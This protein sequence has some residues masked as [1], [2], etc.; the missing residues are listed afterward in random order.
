MEH[1]R[2]Y[3]GILGWSILSNDACS[4]VLR[5]ALDYESSSYSGLWISMFFCV[6]W[7]RCI[8]Q[9][10]QLLLIN[11]LYH[12]WKIY[13]RRCEYEGIFQRDFFNNND[14]AEKTKYAWSYGV[15]LLSCRLFRNW[16]RN[17]ST[18]CFIPGIIMAHKPWR[19]LKGQL[20]LGIN[21]D[22]GWPWWELFAGLYR[23]KLLS[24]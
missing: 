10:G 4:P 21:R 13:I 22:C 5:T 2:K 18:W 1:L 7:V 14:R 24:H 11:G 17:L 23:T 19:E 12:F 15:R 3:A 9:R 16:R 20:L 8:E 6:Y